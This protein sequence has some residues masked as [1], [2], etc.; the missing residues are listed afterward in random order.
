MDD[1]TFLC[2]VLFYVDHTVQQFIESQLKVV[3]CLEDIQVT[4]LDYQ[5]NKLNDKIMS[6]ED[7][8]RMPR[9]ILVEVQSKVRERDVRFGTKNTTSMARK[10][11]SKRDASTQDNTREPSTSRARFESP[12]DWKLPPDIKYSKAFPKATL[13]NIPTITVDG[14]TRPFCNKLFSLQS[15]CNGQKCFFSHASLAD[16]EK[17]EEMNQFYG[18]VY[19]AAKNT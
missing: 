17:T 15:C 14:K 19:A 3:A 5:M 18:A 9:A 1:S 13:A 12:A 8:C 7:I 11:G 4:R 2:K 6:R 10:T 16:H